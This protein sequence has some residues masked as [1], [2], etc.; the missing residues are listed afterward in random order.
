MSLIV[1]LLLFRN[2]T[3]IEADNSRIEN[4]T[5]FFQELILIIEK[6][7]FPRGV[8]KGIVSLLERKKWVQ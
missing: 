1:A 4:E 7:Y 6:V 2:T 5:T 8:S 3:R